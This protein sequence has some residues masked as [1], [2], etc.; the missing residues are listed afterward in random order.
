MQDIHELLDDVKAK[1][2]KLVEEIEVFKNARVLNQSTTES[3]IALNNAMQK[4]LGAIKIYTEPQVLK[5]IRLF[6]GALL[7]N[8]LLV[9][10]VL[11]LLI[12]K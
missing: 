2:Q 3:L 6:G 8:I 11:I 4:T 9:L 5:T 12:I 10:V 1:S 7:L